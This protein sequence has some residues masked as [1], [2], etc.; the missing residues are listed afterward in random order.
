[1]IRVIDRDGRWVLDADQEDKIIAYNGETGVTS[2]VFVLSDP[3]YGDWIYWINVCNADGQVYTK[4]LVKETGT[5]GVA[6]RWD[7]DALDSLT[8]GACQVSLEARKDTAIKRSGVLCLT[9][10]RAVSDTQDAGE[11]L[12]MEWE[13][14]KQY[15]NGALEDADAAAGRAETAAKTATDEANKV[16][17]ASSEMQ[18]TYAQIKDSEGGRV[19]AETARAA[20]EQGRSSAEQERK[21][22]E[23][24][25]DKSE[26]ER[27]TAEGKR[28]MAEQDRTSAETARVTEEAKRAEAEAARADAEAQRLKDEAIR[29]DR[30][31]GRVTAERERA[32][33]EQSRMSAETVRVSAEAERVTAETGRAA[34]ETARAAAEQVRQ[35]AEQGRVNAEAGRVAAETGRA[36]AEQE[37]EQVAGELRAFD[38]CI[39]TAD[40][41]GTIIT[42]DDAAV[43]PVRDMVVHGASYQATDGAS[44]NLLDADAMYATLSTAAPSAIQQTTYNG[45]DCISVNASALYT[46]HYMQGEFR[47]NTAYT[48]SHLYCQ[49]DGAIGRCAAIAIKYTDGSSATTNTIATT[50]WQR[51][52]FTSNPDKTIDYIYLS[53]IYDGISYFADMQ[54]ELGDAAT[55]YVP[56]YPVMPSM[57]RPSEIIGVGDSGTLDIT[58]AEKNL[59]SE[60]VYDMLGTWDLTQDGSGTYWRA[61]WLPIATNV[62]YTLS[63]DYAKADGEIDYFY[64]ELTDSK[65]FADNFRRR[66]N[67]LSSAYGSTHKAVPI[68][69]QPGQWISIWWHTASTG[70]TKSFAAKITNLQLTA[71]PSEIA[72]TPPSGKTYTVPLQDV[73][74]T[75]HTMHS[76]R[77]ISDTIQRRDDGKW[78][79]VKRT[80]EVTVDSTISW[81]KPDQA[82]AEIRGQ[83]QGVDYLHGQNDV[84]CLCT[85]LAANARQAIWS[86][87]DGIAVGYEYLTVSTISHPEW[88]DPAVFAALA[89]AQ[90]EAGTPI[91]VVGLLQTPEE[92]VLCDDA[93]AVLDNIYTLHGLTHISVS[94]CLPVDLDVTYVRDTNIVVDRLQDAADQAEREIDDLQACKSAVLTASTS[95]ASVT[96]DDAYSG[97]P[98][99]MAKIIGKTTETG[100]G[101][102]SAANPYTISGVL[103]TAITAT[104]KNL[105]GTPADI[106]AQ[107][108]KANPRGNASY[109]LGLLPGDVGTTYTLSFDFTTRLPTYPD[110]IDVFIY[111]NPDFVGPV[112]SSKQLV[113]STT[114][115]RRITYTYTPADG[116]YYYFGLWT[117]T[118]QKQISNIMVEAGGAATEYMPYISTTTDLPALAPLYSLPDGATDEYDVVTGVETRRVLAAVFKGD[119]DWT[120]SK[121]YTC[122][123]CRDVF[124]TFVSPLVMQTSHGQTVYTYDASNNRFQLGS[125]GTP[126]GDYWGANKTDVSV[127]RQYL[128]NQYAAGTPVTVICKLAQPVVTQHSPSQIIPVGADCTIRVDSGDINVAYIQDAN[129]VIRKLQDAIAAL[130]LTTTNIEEA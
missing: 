101:T 90:A 42:V 94:D 33:A 86:G 15:I 80:R 41:S 72:Y 30:E 27:S 6:L 14:V 23:S 120:Y 104:G 84:N 128:A 36:T 108:P 69:A 75:S 123:I 85:H 119:E 17:D 54:I 40:V 115:S 129:I 4:P 1:M 79:I 118:P 13:A 81:K 8:D 106:T 9:I 51:Y 45:K 107:W 38:S 100:S 2:R 68:T 47:A 60:T 16:L 10:A 83:V 64:T 71:T 121:N 116:E 97:A 117:G 89:A 126:F 113:G 58:V 37:R 32:T 55:E 25:R 70:G 53:Y 103:P 7:I 67:M 127:W 50:D 112:K 52:T 26:S 110:Y 35:A 87:G 5:S 22:A 125:K 62:P 59:L 21:D 11:I 105:F 122:M 76:I 46:T 99:M 49:A 130:Q 43:A 28:I 78:V 82:R 12:Q 88:D 74:G 93:Q 98:L 66:D 96:L 124:P 63:F 3:Y 109:N 61:I 65:D 56:Y 73:D 95:G 34:A 102:K 39:L 24:A 44:K 92:Y 57:D 19:A 48:I 31:D 91:K 18:Q 20:A 114:Q 29:V 111:N 77:G